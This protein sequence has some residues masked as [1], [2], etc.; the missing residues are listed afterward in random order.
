MRKMSFILNNQV[1]PL[2][3]SDGRETILEIILKPEIKK[4]CKVNENEIKRIFSETLGLTSFNPL[5]SVQQ[6]MIQKKRTSQ[7]SEKIMGY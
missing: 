5:I 3:L 2:V 6:V 1:F 7:I 4:G